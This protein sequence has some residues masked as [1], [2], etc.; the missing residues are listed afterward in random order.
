MKLISIYTFFGIFI[1]VLFWGYIP[2]MDPEFWQT[3]S[4]IFLIGIFT[5]FPLGLSGAIAFFSFIYVL[6]KLFKEKGYFLYIPNYVEELGLKN[7]FGLLIGLIIYW[8]L[9][10]MFAP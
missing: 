6:K 1:L 10:D 9:F 5:L 7:F 8:T 3:A 4:W 2:I